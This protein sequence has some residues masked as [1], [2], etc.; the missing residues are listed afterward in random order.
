MQSDPLHEL[1][2]RAQAG[3]SAAL[4]AVVRE[5]QNDVFDLALRMLGDVSDAQ[6]A[7]Q[8]VLVRIVTKLGSFRGD[9]KFRTWAYRVAANALLNFRGEL[10]R[11]EISFEQA[12]AQL[13]AAVAQADES[14]V[15]PDP[16]GSVLLD[17]VKLAC[18]HGMLLCLD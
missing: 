1:V 11:P 18:A 2:I 6:D 14:S 15:G 3:D 13:D 4:E 9:S 12:G 10:R 17:E 8:E 7:A 5:I 16:A